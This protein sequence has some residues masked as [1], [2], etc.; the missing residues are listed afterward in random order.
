MTQIIV[1]IL[2]LL[3]YLLKWWLFRKKRERRT[4]YYR[5]TYLKSDEWKRK[6]YIV[7]KRDN[8]H[9]V[10]C[11]GNAT[12]VHHKKYAKRNIGKEPISWLVSIC[13]PCHDSKHEKNLFSFFK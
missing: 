5:N 9:C 1:V 8:W 7:L 6:R 4:Q 12:E 3:A 11:G 13:K 10:Y 2:L